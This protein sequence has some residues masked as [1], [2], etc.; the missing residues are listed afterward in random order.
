MK[1]MFNLNG[2]KVKTALFLLSMGVGASL[3][4]RENV[5]TASNDGSARAEPIGRDISMRCFPKDPPARSFV[6]V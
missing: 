3:S 2:K 1:S 6:L 4:A 5:G